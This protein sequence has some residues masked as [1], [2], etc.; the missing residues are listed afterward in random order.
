MEQYKAFT[1][2]E[3]DTGAF[4]RRI[5][6]RDPSELPEGEVLIRVNYSSLNY[7]D[8]LS[9]TGNKG[10]T[11][12][13]PHTP[14]ID[15]AGTV[16][17]SDS[18]R[19]AKG[20]PVLVTGYDLG[21]NTP[22]GFGQF[23]RVPAEWVVPLPDGLTLR[24]SMILGTAG[25]TAGLC[26][27][28]LLKGGGNLTGPVLVTGA[29]GGVGSATLLLL[30]RLGVESVAVTGKR[31]ATDYLTDLGAARVLARDELLGGPERALERGEYA[32]MVDSVGGELLAAGIK[33]LLPGGVAA[34]CG[35]AASASL[36]TS[37]YPFILRAVSLVGVSSQN[38]ETER[39]LDVWRHLSGP[40][41]PDLEKL[42]AREV[43]LDGLNPE[44]DRMLGGGSRGR[45]LVNLDR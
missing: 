2:H 23:I 3:L 27:Q 44:I 28:E 19:F 12:H 22:G 33:R 9:A 4:E 41:K 13:F 30:S 36:F 39:R 38:T 24:E 18:A 1:V 29:T 15:A 25:F 35:N 14:G 42:L 34:A 37:I 31:D 21:M 16:T 8:A 40:W 26:V 6:K 5:E 45:V 20:A 10:V 7:K 11:R 43:G 32:G 17:A